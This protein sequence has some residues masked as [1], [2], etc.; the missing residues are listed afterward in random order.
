MMSG[1]YRKYPLQHLTAYKYPMKHL[2]LLFLIFTILPLGL[3]ASDVISMPEYGFTINSLGGTTDK[4]GALGTALITFYP[5][6]GDFAPNVN[7]MFQNTN[8]SLDDLIELSNKQFKNLN[9]SVISEERISPSEVI[10]NFTG[11]VGKELRFY[12]RM[13][14]QGSKTYTITATCRKGEEWTQLQ[15]TLIGCVNSFKLK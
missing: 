1:S 10:M 5:G 2:T 7:V 12:S 3:K 15:S 6:N 9:F 8:E 4:T 13:I 11:A 14:K